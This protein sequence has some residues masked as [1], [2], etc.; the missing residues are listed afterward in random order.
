MI[1]YL[2]DYITC[3]KNSE[4]TLKKQNVLTIRQILNFPSKHVTDITIT[5]KS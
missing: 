1:Y 3:R 2:V 4:N 5:Q